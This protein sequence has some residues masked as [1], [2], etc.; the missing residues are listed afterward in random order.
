MNGKDK[1]RILKE[2]RREIAEK[3]DIEWVVSECRHQGN[4]KGTCPKCEAEVRK[5]EAELSLRRR[6]GKA[7]AIVGVSSLCT[8]GLS[9]CSLPSVPS[10]SSLFGKITGKPVIEDIAGMIDTMPTE[11]YLT[12]DTT[13]EN[14][15]PEDPTP[16]DPGYMELDGEVASEDIEGTEETEWIELD[17]DVPA[18]YSH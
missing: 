1:C 16:E 10:I 14:T 6:L 12:G 15:T 8:V 4:C 13:P 5:L 3:N 7:V 11:D 9:A 18:D 2:I 17:G